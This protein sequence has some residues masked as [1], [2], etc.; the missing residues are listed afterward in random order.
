MG[1]IIHIVFSIHP[2]LA[3]SSTDGFDS[4]VV[5]FNFKNTT[6]KEALNQIILQTNLQ[7]TYGNEIVQG[8]RIN[9]NF[10]KVTIPALLDSIIMAKGLSYNIISKNQLVIFKSKKT[11]YKNMIKGYIRDAYS[12]ETLPYANIM[13]RDSK[14]GVTSNVSGYFVLLDIP[15]EPCTLDV[16]YIGYEKYS[17]ILD[18]ENRL[19]LLNIKMKQK[20]IGGSEIKVVAENIQ[21]VEIPKDPSYVRISPMQITNMPVLGTPDLLRSLQTLPGISGMNDGASGIF[22]RGGTPDQNLILLD[23]MP[24][25]HMDHLFGFISAFNI[26]AVKD[27]RVMKSAFPTKYGGRLSGVIELTG[28]SGNSNAFQAG[29]NLGAMGGSAILQAPLNKRGGLFISYRR[30][31]SELLGNE[32]Y[33][34]ILNSLEVAGKKNEPGRSRLVNTEK[35]ANATS[36]EFYY[37]DLNSKL[38]YML[39]EQDLVSFSFYRGVDFLDQSGERKSGNGLPQLVNIKDFT[40]WQNIGYSGNWSRRWG[41]TF[42]SNLTIANTQYVSESERTSEFSV[43]D[44]TFSTFFEKTDLRNFKFRLDNEWQFNNSHKLEF[45]G[46]I[47]GTII[48]NNYTSERSV[49]VL[50]QNKQAIEN[51]LYLEDRWQMAEPFQMTI[52]LRS[53]YYEPDDKWYFEPRS[54]FMYDLSQHIFIKAAWGKYYQFVYRIR[55]ESILDGN[56]DLWLVADQN[57]KPGISEQKVVGIGFKTNDYLFDVEAYHKSLS[58]VAEFTQIFRR[59]AD[60]RPGPLFFLGD[61]K[62]YGI[63]FLLQKKRGWLTGWLGY[64]L[65]K[66]D[67][68]IPKINEGRWY[69]ASQDRRHEINFAAGHSWNHWRLSITG[70]YS[71]GLPYTVPGQLETTA[72]HQPEN[73]FAVN[74]DRLPENIRFDIGINYRF[75]LFGLDFKADF[76]I[77]NLLNRKNIWARQFIF[78]GGEMASRDVTGLGITPTLNMSVHF[79]QNTR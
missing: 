45:G 44:S 27:V 75:S 55:N 37:Y 50:E 2:V 63:E 59:S 42:F 32:F 33:T 74:N 12:A 5:S 15:A 68:K 10:K 77:Y 73:V 11:Q 21:A 76:S 61:G 30:S 24:I 35:P 18:E 28:K 6:L 34:D 41:N 56:R 47:S 65:A 79:K 22:I 8:I 39:T 1:L 31:N 67:Y 17:I 16:R 9:K 53:T 48:E 70:L 14:R 58:N 26:D 64:T 71:S 60:N 51:A 29:V 66:V 40:E 43:Q 72:T 62:A 52:G 38:S 36:L 23:G 20:A 3:Q 49:Q 46:Q 69:A 57:L 19:G 54:S 13:I 25:Y 78:S 7:I 4:T